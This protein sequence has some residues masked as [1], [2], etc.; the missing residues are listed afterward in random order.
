MLPD[1]FQTESSREGNFSFSE[2]LFYFNQFF[3]AKLGQK[4]AYFSFV[5]FIAGVDPF[6]VA[7]FF[8]KI[9]ALADVGFGGVG[10]FDQ[11]ARREGSVQF[12]SFKDFQTDS[13]KVHR[14]EDIFI[15]DCFQSMRQTDDGLHR[16]DNILFFHGT[17]DKKLMSI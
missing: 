17:A 12:Q 14:L 15:G 9:Q 7:L 6:Y 8:Q 11:A 1:F 4:D 16:R 5:V 2:S 13:G 10:Y 3:L